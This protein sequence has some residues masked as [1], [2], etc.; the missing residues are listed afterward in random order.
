MIQMYVPTST[1]EDEEI[2]QLYEDITL[3][4]KTENAL[5]HDCGRF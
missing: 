2:E 4:L 3:A 1:A 5:L